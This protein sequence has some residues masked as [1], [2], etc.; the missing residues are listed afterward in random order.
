MLSEGKSY[1]LFDP[2]LI[3]IPGICLFLLVLSINM[4][5][6]DFQDMMAPEA[7]GT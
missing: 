2:W 5:G 4:I 7:R 6:D 3:T 1:I